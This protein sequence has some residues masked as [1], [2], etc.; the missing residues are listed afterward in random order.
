MEV[1]QEGLVMKCQNFECR[2]ETP[3]DI[4]AIRSAMIVN[5]EE[6]ARQLPEA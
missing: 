1:L 4:E 5:A 2:Q 6:Q 3:I